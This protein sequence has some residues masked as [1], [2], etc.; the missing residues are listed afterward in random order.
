M[1]F[2]KTIIF[3]LFLSYFITSF[4]TENQIKLKT[5]FYYLAEK[6]N[7]GELIK[8]IDSEN[9]YAV[10]KTEILTSED[11]NSVKFVTINSQPNPLKVLNIKLTKNGRKKW[12]EI[13]NRI[14]KS[15]ES[16]LFI[17]NN[18]VYL[19][20]KKFDVNNIENSS[21]DLFIEPKHQQT[22]LEIIKSEINL[23]R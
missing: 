19:E 21:I 16:I 17:C 22:V 13:R 7:E 5:G 14:N 23:S 1:K 18:T 20:K 4:T 15:G 10:D 2:F 6:E 8:D 3:S 9:S 12:V 11:F